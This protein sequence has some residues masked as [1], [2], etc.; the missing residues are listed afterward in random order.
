MTTDQKVLG[1]NPNAV[2]QCR[3]GFQRLKP[4]FILAI[5]GTFMAQSGIKEGIRTGP[6]VRKKRNVGGDFPGGW[7]PG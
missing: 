1:L 6:A 5:Y 7:H 2:T 4:F 3:Q